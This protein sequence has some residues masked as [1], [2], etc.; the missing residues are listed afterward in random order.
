MNRSPEDSVTAGAAGQE[1]TSSIRYF[2]AA[3]TGVGILFSL[4]TAWACWLV[5]QGARG[6]DFLSFWAAG[7]MVFGGHAYFVYDILAHRA[8]EFTIAQPRGMLPFPY[9]PPFLFF[10]APFAVPPFGAGFTLWLVATGALYVYGSTRFTQWP[11]ALANPPL[12]LNSMIGQA[13]FLMSGIFMVGLSLIARRPLLAGIV[14]G[15][16]VLKPQLALLLPFATIAGRKWLVVAGAA[17]SSSLLLLVALAVFGVSAY[18]G[19]LNIIPHYTSS[20]QASR[21][22]WNELVSPFALA[23]FWGTPQTLALA[24]HAV[25]A[26][27]AAAIT[28]RAWWLDLDEKIPVLAAATLL[29]S[30][31]IFTY[32]A[33]L[34]IVPAAWL[35]RQGRFAMVTI[36]WLLSLTP[37]LTYFTPW[38]WP[39]L[40]PVAAVLCLW[41]LT[42]LPSRF[43]YQLT[44]PPSG[45]S[46]PRRGSVDAQV[47]LRLSIRPNSSTPHELSR[48]RPQS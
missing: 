37:L 35:V 7:R 21:W 18:A 4:G 34:L 43:R 36:L 12:L 6:V 48:R 22:P 14:L 33:L 8:V 10:V 11:Y 19:F 41:L 32:D 29:I 44:D 1:Q 15:L 38:V 23:R 39:N 40:V 30:P 17:V 13:G 25:V 9:P 20:L 3:A 45:L 27:A 5:F 16:L 26:I 24:I 31:Y 2:R 42:G 46:A 28:T 47:E